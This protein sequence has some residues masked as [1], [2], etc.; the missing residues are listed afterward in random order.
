MSALKEVLDARAI[1]LRR[2][3]SSGLPEGRIGELLR[4]AE[5]TVEEVRVLAKHLKLPARELIVGSPKGGGAF[6]LRT[7]FGKDV[8]SELQFEAAQATYRAKRVAEFCG[9]TLL[10]SFAEYPKS[11]TGAEE[12]AWIFRSY[13]LG[14]NIER[15]LLDLHVLLW[16]RLRVPAV[17]GQFRSIE[18]VS[19]RMLES[20][21][22]LL[23][24]RHPGRMRFTLAHEICH[25]LVDL[26]ADGAEVWLDDKV[27]NA[28][29]GGDTY[30]E[31]AFANAFA[32]ALLMP[33]SEVAA[34]LKKWRTRNSSPAEGITALEVMQV[35]RTFGTSFQVA[36][37]RLE[38]LQLLR[39]G[40][41]IAMQRSLDKDFG[42]PEKFAE[43]YGLGPLAAVDW[44]FPARMI[45]RDLEPSI[46]HGSISREVAAEV[47]GLTL[48]Q[49]MVVGD[50]SRH[51]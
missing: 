42:S 28:R 9:R 15:P 4:D 27:V 6:K 32:A 10:P 3:L 43:E 2:L 1:P 25:L 19:T 26:D 49:S 8:S 17:V 20:A 51:H 16:D 38:T 7:N 5:P 41:A 45:M 24:P 33:S 21:V 30:L 50:A 13:F 37:A 46:A 48:E 12:L 39:P 11:L 36:G 47:L 44:A 34:V 29:K 31:E 23:A 35:A 40:G 18:G 14:M 22:V